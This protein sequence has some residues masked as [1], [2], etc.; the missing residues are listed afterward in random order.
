[1]P[2]SSP[3]LASS[4]STSKPR[5]SAQRIIIRS[6]ISAQS[7]ASVPPAP[8]LT[9]TSASPASYG[10]EKSRASSSSPSRALDAVE[11]L[12]DL[13]GERLVLVGELDQRLEVVDVALELLPGLEPARG[14]RVLGADLGGVLLVV[15]EAGRAHVAL[16]LGDAPREPLGVEEAVQVRELL[17]DRRDALRRRLRCLRGGHGSR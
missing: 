17:A 13:V 15:P 4:S 3:G 8:A 5:R 10:P 12:V 16:E 1:M 14:A 7:C 11:L 9:V 6:T 2:A